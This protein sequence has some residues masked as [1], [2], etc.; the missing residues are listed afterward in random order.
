MNFGF[1]VVTITNGFLMIRLIVL[2]LFPVVALAGG[3][4]NDN[5][6]IS[7]SEA[8][9]T[10]RASAGA[11]VA[12]NVTMNGVRYLELSTEVTYQGPITR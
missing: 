5:T 2:L 3:N 10:S 7:N 4:H 6:A 9:A 1:V 8:L 11:N 12:N